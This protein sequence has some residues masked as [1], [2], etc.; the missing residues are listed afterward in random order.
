MNREQLMHLAVS[1]TVTFPATFPRLAEI[2]IRRDLDLPLACGEQTATYLI[3]IERPSVRVTM[4]RSLPV[5]DVRA[6]FLPRDV[7]CVNVADGTWLLG[8]EIEVGLRM[9]I[10]SGKRIFGI[11][12]IAEQTATLLEVQAGMTAAESSQYYP[13]LPCD[14][15]VNHYDPYRQTISGAPHLQLDHCQHSGGS[16]EERRMRPCEPFEQPACEAAYCEPFEQR[17]QLYQSLRPCEGFEPRYA[18]FLDDSQVEYQPLQPC[19]GFEPA[20]F[21]I[22][23]NQP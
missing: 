10:V 5:R 20:A 12:Y 22:E 8:S 17:Q 21:P 14:R 18:E 9:Q 16:P 15:S 19:D 23:E 2:H 13:P 3:A 1:G 4:K 6:V 7:N 11:V